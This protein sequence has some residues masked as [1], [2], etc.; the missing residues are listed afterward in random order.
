MKGDI[1]NMKKKENVILYI[2]YDG[3]LEPLGQSQVLQY[4]EK[5]SLKYQIVLLTFEKK[6]D[7]SKKDLVKYTKLKIQDSGIV[8]KPMKYHNKVKII[9]K[10]LNLI[11]GMF[12]SIVQVKK[13]NACLVHC[14]S[15]MSSILGVVIKKIFKIPLVFDMRGFWVDEKVTSGIWLKSSFYYKMGKSIEKWILLN[16]DVVLSLTHAA[17]NEMKQFEY[18]RGKDIDFRTTTTCTNLDKF[19]IIDNKNKIDE[20]FIVGYIGTAGG[21]QLF[22]EVVDFFN[23]V[24]VVKKNSHLIIINKDEHEYIRKILYNKNISEAQYDIYESSYEE[25]PHYINKFDIGLFFNKPGFARKASAPT[26]LG[27]YL[28]CGVPVISNSSI[29]DIESILCENGVGEVVYHFTNDEY[30]RAINDLLLKLEDPNIS[31]KCRE[32]AEDYF[33]LDLGVQKY[34]QIYSDYLNK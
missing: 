24:K 33:S 9:S 26:R 31:Y 20:R 5:L 3:L 34:N 17:V 12:I 13:Y 7:W 1:I 14:R 10:I 30:I 6:K 15:Y 27:E 11:N 32:V 2:S 22:N 19:R 29:G 21:W 18:I 23:V 28:A 25:M 8:W 4:L 16:S